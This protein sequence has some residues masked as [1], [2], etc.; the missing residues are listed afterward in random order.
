MVEFILFAGLEIRFPLMVEV[1]QALVLFLV[2]KESIE[3]FDEE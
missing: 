3:L 2:A 1:E